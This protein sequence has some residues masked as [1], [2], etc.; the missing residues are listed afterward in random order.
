[1]CAQKLYMTLVH[2]EWIEWYSCKRQSIGYIAALKKSF[3]Y[4]FIWVIE[5]F[6]YLIKRMRRITKRHAFLLPS[7][8]LHF[9][10]N[11]CL[12]LHL[13]FFQYFFFSGFHCL[14]IGLT[15][16]LVHPFVF[17][18]LERNRRKCIEKEKLSYLYILDMYWNSMTKR[19][20]MWRYYYIYCCY[21]YFSDLYFSSMLSVVVKMSLENFREITSLY[22]FQSKS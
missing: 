19:I 20:P 18:L 5:K 17:I 1:M 9:S 13:F 7:L 3:C 6:S 16:A 14:R 8:S 10:F 22:T 11:V 15:V 4:Y 2:F 21:Y 12:S